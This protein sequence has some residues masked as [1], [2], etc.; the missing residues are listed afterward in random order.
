MIKKMVFVPTQ[1]GITL[2]LV[3]LDIMEV[4][5]AALVRHNCDA[6]HHGYLHL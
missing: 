1:W 3:M 4:V 2:V 5:S 6:C